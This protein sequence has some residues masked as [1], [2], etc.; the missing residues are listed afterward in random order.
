MEI[1][2]DGVALTLR[3]LCDH[4]GNLLEYNLEDVV[5][6]YSGPESGTGVVEKLEDGRL[7]IFVSPQT[8]GTYSAQV[9]LYGKPILARD[10]SVI[11]R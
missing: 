10:V 7:R 3:A 5:L 8:P 11:V 2:S 6:E 1:T 9:F 4:E